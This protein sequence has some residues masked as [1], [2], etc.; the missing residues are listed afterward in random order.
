MKIEIFS[1]INIALKFCW[2]H[3]TQFYF[4]AL[5]A[6]ITLAILSTLVMAFQPPEFQHALG[7][8]TSGQH[9]QFSKNSLGYL[10]IG[11][12]WQGFSA[13]LLLIFTICIFSLYSVAW[14]RFYLVPKEGVKISD[15]YLW[16]NR[17]WKFLWSNLKIFLFIVPIGLIAFMVTLTSAIFA[18][19]VGLITILF[20]IICYARF[21]MWLPAVALDQKLSLREVLLLTKGNGGRL[22]AILILTGLITGILDGMATGLIEHASN[23]LHVVGNLTQDLLT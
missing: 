20:V 8:K 12:S 13:F 17:H 19:L 7:F 16:K 15:C 4:L 5:P 23:S 10:F 2:N 14:H 18:P 9:I 21:S 22:A 11:S 3:R 1:T 6:V